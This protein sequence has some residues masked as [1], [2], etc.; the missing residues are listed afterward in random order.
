MGG[1]SDV[2]SEQLLQGSENSA[3]RLQWRFACR[4]GLGAGESTAAAVGAVAG[5]GCG[6]GAAAP[7]CGA[8]AGTGVSAAGTGATCGWAAGRGAGV[9]IGTGAGFSAGTGAGLG[10][11]R[12]VTGWG[13]GP[14]PLP[15][16]VV[17]LPDGTHCQY[18]GRLCP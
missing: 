12:G 13:V 18:H 17:T 1:Y 11:G 14:S 7:V 8:A 6:P 9:A 2:L 10:A 4:E 15:D 3:Q 16:V 5:F